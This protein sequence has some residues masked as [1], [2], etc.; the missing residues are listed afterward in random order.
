MW[1]LS[2]LSCL[3]ADYTLLPM[4]ANPLILYG[5]MVLFLIIPFKTAY[6]KSR[7]WLIKLL[8]REQPLFH[9][10]MVYSL[11][12]CMYWCFEAA[13]LKPGSNR[14]TVTFK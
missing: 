12:N 2:I 8:V 14:V 13:F 10:E 7:F 3:F 11:E 5:F 9:I 1:C 4:Q 6:Y